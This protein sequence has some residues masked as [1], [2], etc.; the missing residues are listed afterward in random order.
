MSKPHPKIELAMRDMISTQEFYACLLVHMDFV[1]DPTQPTQGTDGK[2]IFYNPEFWK[3]ISRTQSHFELAHEACHPMFQHLTR[4][5]EI[6]P[7][8]GKPYDRVIYN[9]A[10]DH[11]INL[12]L[13]QTGFKIPKDALCDPK[14]TNWT[15]EQVYVH[16][17][18]NEKPNPQQCCNAGR[19]GKGLMQPADDYSEV[20][21]Q[22]LVQQAAAIARGRGN[23]PGELE[24]IVQKVTE[25][26]YPLHLLMERFVDQALKS[27]ERT[28]RKPHQ[29]FMARGIILPGEDTEERVSHA[30]MTYDVSGSVSNDECDYIHALV[31]KVFRLLKPQRMTLLMVDTA[32]RKVVELKD[33][34]NWP[35]KIRFPG[36][37]GT[38]FKPPF[39]WLR[40]RGITPSCLIYLTDLDGPFPD[41]APPYP[42]MWVAVQ[43]EGQAPFGQT[44]YMPE[45]FR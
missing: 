36:R 17:L 39:D 4:Q 23:L 1:E 14:F 42:V 18:K 12:L 31:K 33:T 2:H 20:Q 44:V 30:V 29:A 7:A 34:D 41:T 6:C 25:P 38:D 16:L 8:T 27:E 32:V 5:K 9:M 22:Q 15:T 3:K 24:A 37:G 45:G 10:G 11:V 35:E 40:S 13:K 43:H 21:Q 26:S 28:W 19:G